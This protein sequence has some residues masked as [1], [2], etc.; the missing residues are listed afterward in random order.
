MKKEFIYLPEGLHF[1]EDYK[2][3]EPQILSFHTCVFNKVVTGCGATTMFLDDPL[4]TILCSPRK[5][6]MFWSW[7]TASVYRRSRQCH[8]GRSTDIPLMYADNRARK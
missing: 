1:L 3:L 5:A 6:L 8:F 7:E 4:P 2:E